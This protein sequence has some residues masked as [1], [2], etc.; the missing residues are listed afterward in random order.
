MDLA[1]RPRRATEIVDA[2]VRLYR[3]HF[4]TFVT[5]SV[6]AVLPTLLVQLGTIALTNVSAPGP[7]TLAAIGAAGLLGGPAFLAYTVVVA[8][9][10]A[11][12]SDDAVQ[13]DAPDAGRAVRRGVARA[14]ACLGALL[15]FGLA[16]F[17]GALLLVLPGL[18]V[19]ARLATVVP[20]VVVEDAGPVEAL[21]R[22]WARSRGRA[23]HSLA[24]LLVCVLLILV[25]VAASGLV[26]GL[27]GGPGA[28][29]GARVAAALVGA[30]LNVLVQPL[31]PLAT[32]L[33]YYDLR[34]RADGYDLEQMVGSLGAD[35]APAGA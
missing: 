18:Y 26:D 19:A 4:G 21:K 12:L 31:F 9:A 28:S 34:V 1:F 24:V 22:A 32:Q 14:W 13:T 29:A 2:A 17:A 27:V 15:L 20:T 5:L 7:G 3:R 11:A 30:A 35:A 25:P 16:F 33:L 23:W 6:L 8:G 10:F